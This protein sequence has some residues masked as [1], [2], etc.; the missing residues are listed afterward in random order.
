MMLDDYTFTAGRRNRE[1]DHQCD[2]TY[3]EAQDHAREMA[4]RTGKPVRWHLS[5]NPQEAEWAYPGEDD[6]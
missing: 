3:G 5:G 6:R 1:E 2:I 4:E